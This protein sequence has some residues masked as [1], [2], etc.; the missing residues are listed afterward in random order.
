[1]KKVF[2]NCML[3]LCALIVGSS[4]VWAAE[5]VYKT[6]TFCNAGTSSNQTQDYTSSWTETVSSFGWTIANFNNNKWGWN[7]NG[8]PKLYI[9]KCG[10]KYTG[11]GN[12]I[13]YTPSVATITTNAAIDQAITKVVVTLTAINSGD[14]NSI[15][16]Y[17]ASTSAFDENNDEHFATITVSPIPSSAGNMTIT[18]PQANRAANRYYQL[19]FDTKGT[20]SGNGHTGIKKVEYYYEASP[21][22]SIALSGTY[23][24]TFYVGD[25]FSHT[26]MTVTATYEN[27]TTKNVT[28]SANFTS[29]DMSSAGE[30]P[31]TVS[32]TENNIEKSTSYNITINPRPAL[33]SA[34]ETASAFSYLVGSGPSAAQNFTITGSNLAGK[35]TATLSNTTEFEMKTGENDYSAGPLTNL[36][37]GSIVSVRL[38]S[39]LSRNISISGNLTFSS[40]DAE[41]VVISLSGSVTKP[42]HT[43]TFSINGNTSRS[44]SVEEDQAVTFPSAVDSPSSASEFC[45]TLNGKVF[46]G[47]YGSTYTH[48][49]TAPTYINTAEEV[50]GDGNVTYYA[51]YATETSTSSPET[52]SYGWENADD[53]TDWTITD[54]IVQTSG[55]GNTG[56]YAGKINTNN[57]YVKFNSKVNVTSFSF[58]FKRTSNNENYNVYIET[59]TNGTSW[60]AAETYAMSGFSNGSY[61]TKSK[62]FDGKTAYYVRFH[63]NNTTAVRYVDDVSITYNKVTESTTD[64]C[65]TVPNVEITPT[66]GDYYSTCYYPGFDLAIPDGVNAYT[67]R[68]S[69]VGE[70]TG[71]L[72]LDALAEGIIPAG[73]PV[74]LKAESDGDLVNGKIVL[75]PVA[76]KT[77][78]VGTNNLQGSDGSATANSAT[79]VLGQ[80]NL[81]SGFYKLESGTE[82]PANKAYLDLSGA[83]APSAIR[84]EMEENNATDIENIQE[85]EKAIKFFNNGQLLILRDGITYDALGRIVR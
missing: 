68:Y 5:S 24:T 57:T 76:S 78:F 30:K 38:K 62:T 54:A 71:L 16:L 69:V 72:T 10:R 28:S 81:I 29:P 22:A 17:M 20:T 23:P 67:A 18:I 73:V 1:M 27:S 11:S 46:K 74:V 45:K 4:S 58:A 33:T 55:Q 48:A 44:A 79:Y 2:L 26:G 36:E 51:V 12:N 70:S 49:S 77:S 40:T 82:I 84:F 35:I 75:T 14:Y 64:F 50:M 52:K 63:C 43:A 6:L 32:Y 61:Q 59:S 8:N 80:V 85:N 34:P 9:V 15:K 31:V 53:A 3:L 39:G 66:P 13:T 47:W 37:S 42:F 65:T 25:E 56:S 7:D 60:S 21:L 19:E 41:N 83:N